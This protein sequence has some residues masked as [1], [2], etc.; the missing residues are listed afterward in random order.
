LVTG[1]PEHI[2]SDVVYD[3]AK[4]LGEGVDGVIYLA[5]RKAAGKS[6]KCPIQISEKSLLRSSGSACDITQ[7]GTAFKLDPTVLKFKNYCLI[8]KGDLLAITFNARA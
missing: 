4:A 3:L 8:S 7:R 6:M 5:E 2:G 1:G